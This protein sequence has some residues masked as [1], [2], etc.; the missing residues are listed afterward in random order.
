MT[1]PSL[2]TGPLLR[3][4][5]AHAATVWVETDRPAQVTVLGAT[6]STWSVHGR[7]FALVEI[8]GLE[9]GTTI[10]YEVHLDGHHVWPLDDSAYPPSVI[11]TL[12]PTR[13]FQLA[14]GSC[15]RAAPLDSAATRAFG[16]DALVALTNRIAGQPVDTWPDALLL[17]GDQIY[18]DKPSANLGTDNAS[19]FDDYAHLYAEAWLPGPIRWLLSTVP[20][21]MILDDHDLR[22]D[23]NTSL[24]WRDVVTQSPDWTGLVQGAFGSYFVYQHLGN[25][26]PHQLAQNATYRALRDAPD[27]AERAQILD[28]FAWQ[29]D[30]TPDS[31][32]W[33]FYRDFGVDGARIR[34]LVVD[35]RCSRQLTP[36]DRRIV[37]ATE[38]DWLKGVLNDAATQHLLVASTLP[39]FLFHGIHDLEGW[40]EAVTAGAWGTRWM[41]RGEKIRQAV[42]LE[43]WAAFRASF[44]ELTEVLRAVIGRA[45]PPRSVL[46]LSGDVH[47]SY[48]ARVTL[49][50]LPHA[51]TVVHQLTMSPFRNPLE[52]HIRIANLLLETRGVRWLTRRLARAAGVSADSVD[53]TVENGP[54]FDNGVMT[55]T[56]EGDHVR[57]VVDHAFAE[58]GT[59]QLVE[60]TTIDLTGPPTGRRPAVA[61]RQRRRHRRLRRK[62]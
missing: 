54:W 27:D 14:F 58:S 29:S 52:V 25:L 32:R 35:A 28:D 3:Y 18:A 47:C 39:V 62:V 46:F 13:P 15:R 11:R 2:V 37:D 20:T 45:H 42:D 16:A 55:I 30:A 44:T 36:S 34:L 56:I 7:H 22:D 19:T 38:A 33:S 1:A 21:C 23:W 40:N 5:D 59:H 50:D 24:A 51:P 57:V 26:S 61:R 10:P 6:T 53:W 41:A 17:A 12:S 48:T 60:T 4:A 9:A 8:N 49:T 43:H 31:A